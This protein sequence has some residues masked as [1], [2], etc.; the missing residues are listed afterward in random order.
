MSC[1]RCKHGIYTRDQ[2]L[3]QLRDMFLKGPECT[4]GPELT[5]ESAF[6]HRHM[7]LKGPGSTQAPDSGCLLASSEVLPKYASQPLKPC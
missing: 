2:T 3:S 1:R 4:Q 6:A 7:I 5:Q